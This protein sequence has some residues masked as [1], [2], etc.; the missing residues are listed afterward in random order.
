MNEVTLEK[1][2]GFD[3][4]RQLLER[5]TVALIGFDLRTAGPRIH[6]NAPRRPNSPT[7]RSRKMGRAEGG[8]VKGGND[9]GSQSA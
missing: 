5:L 8:P 4:I 9:G 6:A 7:G 2:E 1:T 3:A